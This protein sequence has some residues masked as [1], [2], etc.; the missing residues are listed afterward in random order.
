MTHLARL[1]LLAAVIILVSPPVPSF[2]QTANQKQSQDGTLATGTVVSST[3]STLVVKTE[4]GEHWLFVLEPDTVKPKTLSPGAKVSI[5]YAR[6]AEGIRV[7]DHVTVTA[8]APQAG[9]RTSGEAAGPIPPE[10]RRVEREIE[11]QVRRF[12]VGVRAGVGLDPEVITAGVHAKLGPFFNQNAFFRP[13]A[14]FGFGEVTT[15]VALN[16]EAVYRLPIT[17]RQSRWSVYVGAG[18]GLNFIDRDFEEPLS[19]G[20]S[21]SFDDFDF[22]PGF[23]ILAGVEFRSGL[24]LE[25]KSSA[26]SVP[27]TRLLIGYNF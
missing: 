11:R 21:I 6:D 3:S 25:L 10:V 18:P 24:F 20:R 8:A 26:F 9:D 16:F 15:L 22:D 17:A 27:H 13:N 1:S 19:E 7:A 23:N 12:R 14:E 5:S 4:S 2:S